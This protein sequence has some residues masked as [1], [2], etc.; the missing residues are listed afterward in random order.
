MCWNIERYEQINEK[1]LSLFCILEPKI[2]VLVIGTGD[3][4]ITPE[5]SKTIMKFMKKFEINVEVLP[6]EQACTTFNFLAGEGRMVGAA[7]IP[8]TLMSVSE[9]D[10]VRHQLDRRNI[11]QIDD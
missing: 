10:Y 2:D 3:N 4:P 11:L 1:T 9:A 7:I 8:P 6:T 5:F